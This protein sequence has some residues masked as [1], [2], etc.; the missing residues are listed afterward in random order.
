MAKPS[1]QRQL[2]WNTLGILCYM[3]LQWL[4]TVLVVRL[5][6]YEDAGNLSLAMSFTVIF[7]SL[8]YFCV[9]NYQA[10]DIHGEFQNGDYIFHRVLT[11][12]GAMGLC[13]VVVLCS[14]YSAGQ[15]VAILLFMGFR[16]TEAAVDVLHGIDQKA[17]RLDIIGKSYLLRGICTFLAFCGVLWL[18]GSLNLAIVCMAA[19]SL[20]CVLCYDVPRTRTLSSLR[21][22][23]DFGTAWRITL[24]SLPIVLCSQLMNL[25]QVFPRFVLEK[26]FGSE[27]LG[28][29]ATIATPTVL[30]SVIANIAFSPLLTLLAEY[31]Q[32]GKTRSFAKSC[33]LFCGGTLLLGVA[34]AMAASFLGEWALGLVFGQ[35]ILPYSYLLVPIIWNVMLLVLTRLL[36][37]VYTVIR[38]LKAFF[39][40]NLLATAAVLAAALLW[41]PQNPL[42]ATN[43]ASILGYLVQLTLGGGYLLLR[44]R[45]IFRKV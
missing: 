13:A 12:G 32:A 33:L 16:I 23:E 34:G 40:I 11:C 17:W 26:G 8:A 18:T 30:I 29:Y 14:G 31:Y 19:A 27:M 37:T 35:G 44:R 45:E 39:I 3:G 4:I 10:S 25:Q 21:P 28:Y 1:I 2:T 41:I 36:L 6:G 20:L 22:I 43:L 5:G 15:S 7:Q 42:P 24:R 38:K 9:R